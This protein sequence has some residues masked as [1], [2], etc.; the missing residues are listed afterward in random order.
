[1]ISTPSGN[2]L[3]SVTSEP[4]PT[5]Q[6]R[7]IF[8]PLSTMLWMPTRLPSPMVQPCSITWW[9][10]V[11]L[12]PMVSGTSWSVC[13]TLPSCTLLWAPTVMRSLSPRSTAPYQTLAFSPNVTRPITSALSATQAVGCTS[14]TS[15]SSW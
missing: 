2:S 5:R 1:M 11:T 3:P 7:P 13:S 9:P 6:L 10:M 4:A 12:R 14:G 8:A 15:S